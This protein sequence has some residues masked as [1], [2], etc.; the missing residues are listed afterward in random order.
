ML[1]NGCLTSRFNIKRGCRQGDPL[2]PYLFLLCAEILGML[3]RKSHKIKGLVIENKEYRIL[4]YAD[5]TV[6]CLDSTE[7]LHYALEL[8]EFFS[9]YSGLSLNINKTQI[10]CIGSLKKNCKYRFTSGSW[11]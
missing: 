6:L 9:Q 7:S 10:L 3:V 1:I 5:D 11:D 8:F 4:Q 2:S